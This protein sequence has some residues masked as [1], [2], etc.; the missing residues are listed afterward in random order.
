MGISLQADGKIVV[1]GSCGEA[2]GHMILVTRFN[3]DGSLDLT[4]GEDG[5]VRTGIRN[6]TLGYD[7]VVQPDNKILVSG[8]GLDYIIQKI[9]IVLV[10]YNLDG[11]LD[12]TF[13]QSGIVFTDVGAT[14][15]ASLG[16]A[17][18][19]QPD[20]KILVTGNTNDYSTLVRYNTDGS[21]DTGI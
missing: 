16:L 8:F 2:Y 4:F 10:R 11:S 3:S 12:N 13:G 19:L 6:Y 9:G 20:N 1:V 18:A 14:N 21:L 15:Y 7:V 17:I 5:F